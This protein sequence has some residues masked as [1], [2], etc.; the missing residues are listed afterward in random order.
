[1][2]CVLVL[3]LAGA[4]LAYANGE[5]DGTD[6]G[7]CHFVQGGLNASLLRFDHDEMIDTCRTCHRDIGPA[8]DTIVRRWT[9][10]RH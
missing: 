9:S 6:C 1:V 4:D 5:R 10:T 7:T 8:G 3:V 2:A